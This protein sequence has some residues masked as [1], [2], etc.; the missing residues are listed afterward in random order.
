MKRII[1]SFLYLLILFLI[2]KFVFDP[3]NLYYELLWLDVPMHILGG[4][5]VASLTNTILI[6][7][8]RN[9]SYFRIFIAYA[10]IAIGWEFYE[11]FFSPTFVHAAYSW[12][13]T[14]SDFING[15]IGASVLYIIV[16]SKNK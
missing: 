9:V 6:Y 10:V 1:Y 11:Y 13:D 8:K 4:I 2:S 5:G 15:L 12:L 14:F 16:R 3:A 7:N